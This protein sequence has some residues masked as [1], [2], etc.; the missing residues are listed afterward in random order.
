MVFLC[1]IC[2]SH[3]IFLSEYSNLQLEY[4]ILVDI[5]SFAYLI[6]EI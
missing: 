2:H 1:D 5:E 3:L 4:V 6:M